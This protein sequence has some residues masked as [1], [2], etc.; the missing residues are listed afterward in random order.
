MVE[1]V[2]ELR[3]RESH[4][5]VEARPLRAANCTCELGR[6]VPPSTRPSAQVELTTVTF[7]PPKR[8]APKH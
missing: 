1:A 8:Y 4:P 3:E 7:T 6:V 5:P 2:S